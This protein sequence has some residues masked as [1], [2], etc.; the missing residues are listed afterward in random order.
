[1][2]KVVVLGGSGVATPELAQAI[3]RVEMRREKIQLVL[4]GRSADKLEKV[5]SVARMLA[6]DD[7]LLE[8]TCTTD[9]NQALTGAEFI[10]NQIRVGGLEARAFDES[11]PQ[12]IGLPGEETVGPGGFAN[13][14]RTIPVVLEYARKM[15]KLCPEATLLSF[16]NPASLVQYAVTK[17]TGLKVIGLCDGPISLTNNIASA[18]GVPANELVV[19]Y[20]GMHHFGWAVDV[21]HNA[22]SV[23]KEVLERAEMANK[24]VAPEIIRAIG[25]VPG[26]YFNYVFHPER[27]LAKKMGKRT[28]AEELLDLQGQ[29]LEDFDKAI[30]SGERPQRLAQRNARWY[31]AIIAPVLLALVERRTEHF[32]LNVVNGTVI[33]WLP[34]EAIIEVPVALEGGKVRPLAVREVPLDLKALIRKN[35]TYEMLAVQAIVE[36]DRQKG[37]RALLQNPIVH[38]YDQAV[39]TLEKAWSSEGL[40]SR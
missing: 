9:L 26:P 10:I 20:V 13:A 5:T 39:A 6:E 7:A 15:E 27:M 1:M 19:D 22:R 33:P 16:V 3:H 28:R 37:L 38:T 4:V 17:Y 36:H 25:A 31:Q 23:M 14:S 32:I 30:E 21:W 12:E 11:F 34:E 35:C 8:I 18:L 29:L 40:N 2:T 24:D